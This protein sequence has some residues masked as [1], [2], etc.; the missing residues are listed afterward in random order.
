MAMVKFLKK[1]KWLLAILIL[2]TFLRVYRL[3][4]VELF[5]DEVDAGYQAY[6]LMTTGRDYKGNLLPTYAQSFSEWRAPGLMYA[7]IPFIKVFGLN[8]WGVRLTSVFFGIT[9]L[10]AWW[11]LMSELKVENKVKIFTTLLLAIIPW[12]VQ[13]SR[14]GYELTLMSTML[15]LGTIFWI[16]AQKSKNFWLILISGTAF[17]AAIYTYNTANIYVPLLVLVTSLIFGWKWSKIWKLLGVGAI[18]CLSIIFSVI[19][20]RA[21]DRFNLFSVWGSKEVSSETINL[22]NEAATPLSRIIYNKAVIS[23]KKIVFNYTNAFGSEFLFNQGDV[24]FRQS[25]HEVGNL[26]WIMA[27]LII[28]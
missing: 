23:T 21:A 28:W 20:G 26:Y 16:K 12:Q 7:M 25:L 4:Y 19:F 27:P 13:Y 18:L 15:I 14:S 8:E 1:N 6:S 9:A 10:L 24:T 11:W 17:A 2:A 5:G 3:N 22:R